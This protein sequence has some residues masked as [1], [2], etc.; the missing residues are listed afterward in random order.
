[1]RLLC[2]EKSIIKFITQ[3]FY[4]TLSG[5]ISKLKLIQMNTLFALI[6]DKV[7][8]PFKINFTNVKSLMRY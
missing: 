6:I 3:L 5:F 7:L 4:T 8:N 1:M 2:I